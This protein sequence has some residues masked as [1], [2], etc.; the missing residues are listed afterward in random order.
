MGDSEMKESH[1]VAKYLSAAEQIQGQG[2]RQQNAAQA[3]L[4]NNQ[5]TRGGIQLMK[6]IIYINF[7][8]L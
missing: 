8:R 5:L 6:M 7:F 3:K 2:H 1:Q 4:Y